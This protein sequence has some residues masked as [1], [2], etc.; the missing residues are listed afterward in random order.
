VKKADKI[1]LELQNYLAN[2]RDLIIP[3]LYIAGS[4]YESDVVKITKSGYIYEFEIKISRSDFF[5]DF[6]KAGRTSTKHERLQQG[7]LHTNYFTFVYPKG[8]VDASEVPEYC[9]IIEYDE[10]SFSKFRWVRFP[11]KLNKVSYYKDT[12]NVFKLMQTLIVRHK[13]YRQKINNYRNETQI[14]GRNKGR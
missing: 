9:G 4:L 14:R 8:L 11:K 3:N 1:S 7:K 10:I 13:V 12:K 2:D 6:K 5:N